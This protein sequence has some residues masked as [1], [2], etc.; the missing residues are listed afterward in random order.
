MRSK[1]KSAKL[2]ICKARSLSPNEFDYHN[3]F[4]NQNSLEQLLAGISF[5][6]ESS[7]IWDSETKLI[8]V[9]FGILKLQ[10]NLEH[11]LTLRTIMSIFISFFFLF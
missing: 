2:K 11:L 7:I 8:S 9:L 4:D 10:T 6:F 5:E 3:S 1:K